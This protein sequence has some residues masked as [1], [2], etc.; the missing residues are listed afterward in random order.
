MQNDIG[1]LLLNNIIEN[2]KTRIRRNVD[3]L[4]SLCYSNKDIDLIQINTSSR[5]TN[6]LSIYIRKRWDK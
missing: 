6:A 5:A 1:N 3:R 4:T 2:K